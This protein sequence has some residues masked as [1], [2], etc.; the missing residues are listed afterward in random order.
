MV[1]GDYYDFIPINKN[2]YVL[3]IADVSGKGMSAAM[4]MSNFQ[5]TL[6]ANVKYNHNNLTIEELV[7]ELNTSVFSAAKGE[8]FI[9]FFIGYYTEHNRM[10]KYINAGHN[11]PILVHKKM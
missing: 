1:S 2:E 6:R 10:L 5:A 7:K 11:Y 4:L 3:C 9:T 8:K